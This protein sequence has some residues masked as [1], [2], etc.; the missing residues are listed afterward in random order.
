MIEVK[1]DNVGKRRMREIEDSQTENGC[2]QIQLDQTAERNFWND[3][4]SNVVGQSDVGILIFRYRSNKLEQLLLK[5]LSTRK[6]RHPEA[7]LKGESRSWRRRT[8]KER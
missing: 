2:Q 7:D 1:L 8:V 3:R 4:I 5:I 6:G